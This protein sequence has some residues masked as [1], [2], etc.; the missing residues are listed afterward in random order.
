MAELRQRLSDGTR[1]KGA[2]PRHCRRPRRGRQREGGGGA[3]CTYSI[4]LQID[5]I[6]FAAE[7]MHPT[8]TKTLS[9]VSGSQ[10]VLVDETSEQ[11]SSVHA[12][13]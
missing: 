3:R 6:R 7:F 12:H 10:F 4:F 13:G 11:I 1:R 9:C 2:V 8:G 5:R